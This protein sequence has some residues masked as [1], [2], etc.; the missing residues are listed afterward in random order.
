MSQRIISP[1]RREITPLAD[2]DCL[3]VSARKKPGFDFPVHVHSEYELNYI[4]GAGGAERIVGDSIETL[5]DYEL[6]LI[7]NEL[8]HGWRNG[9]IKLGECDINEITIQFSR[10]LISENLL[11]KKQFA[12]VRRMF[13]LAKTG[14]SFSLPTILKTK[15]LLN[16]LT[17]ET[18]G[19]FAMTTFMNLLY[20]L[21]LD[22]GI[23]TIATQNI[24]GIEHAA[25]S[26]RIKAVC[27]YID[28]N[29]SKDIH[30]KDLADVSNMSGAA[31]SRFFKHHTGKSIT[32]YIIELRISK[33]SKELIETEKTVAEI[34]YGSGF[35][36]IS[37]F[38]RL[39]KRLKGCTP[40]E[41]RESFRKRQLLV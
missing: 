37:N 26:R 18:T 35:N 28:E 41:F 16:S 21:S 8:E 33:A 24:S 12:S 40:K 17:C 29:Y 27:A 6:V 5:G 39:F 3:Y 14:V 25:R 31:L 34:C 20:E 2:E 38:N 23:R 15:P 36:N 11:S 1:I 7:G 22:P 13:E 19:F 10:D 4:E 32:D 9:S 30:L